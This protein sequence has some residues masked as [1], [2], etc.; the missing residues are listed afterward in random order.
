M[1]YGTHLNCISTRREIPFLIRSIL[2]RPIYNIAMWLVYSACVFQTG[3][4]SCCVFVSHK[5][6]RRN[7]LLDMMAG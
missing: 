6:A 4:Q 3:A 5:S 1:A 2:L 7:A